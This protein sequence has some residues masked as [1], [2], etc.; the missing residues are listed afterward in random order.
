MHYKNIKIIIK[1]I[2]KKEKSS[3]HL[4]QAPNSRLVVSL[5]GII[6]YMSSG[7]DE[8]DRCLNKLQHSLIA[9]CMVPSLT[10]CQTS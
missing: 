2:Y 3:F 5:A 8:N 7:F 6:Y 9:P 1:I 4:H 10:A